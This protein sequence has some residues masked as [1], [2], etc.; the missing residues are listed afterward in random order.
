M[1]RGPLVLIAVLALLLLALTGLPALMRL[2]MDWYWFSA[3][4][5][6]GVFVVTVWTKVLLGMTVGAVAFAFFYLN[7]R[8]SQRGVVPDPIAASPASAR[9]S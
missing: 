1:K 2:A 9:A 3:I 4:G 5:F 6:R 7:L 8:F